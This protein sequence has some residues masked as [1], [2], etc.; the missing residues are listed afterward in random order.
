[1]RHFTFVV[2]LL[3]ISLSSTSQSISGKVVDS[4]KN[5]AIAFA[6]ISLSDGVRGTTSDIEG[7][8]SLRI[9]ADYNG[10]ILISHV[11]Y[12]RVSLPASYFKKAKTIRLKPSETVLSELT[13]FAE[14]NPAFRIIRKAVANREK[15]D[16]DKL[17]SYQYISYNKFLVTPDDPSLKTD[18]LIKKLNAKDRSS[19]SENQKDFL[20]IDSLYKTAHV[21]LSESV[22]EKKV[23]NPDKEI[24][25][26]LAIKVS[27]FKSPLFTN[28]ATDY[29]TFSFYK[30]KITLLQKDF[31][32][33]ISKGTL[34]RY[35]FYL[36]DTSYN[37][38]DTI[39]TIQFEPKQFKFFNGLKGMISIT[40]DGFAVKNVIA[41]DADTLALANIRIQQNYEKIDGH[42]FPTQLNTDLLFS[43]LNLFGR[44]FKI[45]H[46][47][48]LND[49]Q[50]N[51]ELKRILFGDIKIELSVPKEKENILLLNKYRVGT[52]EAKEARTYEYMDSALSK[53]VK[54][55]KGLEALATR[56]IPFRSLDIDINN[57]VRVNDYENFRLGLG[58]FTNDK[59]SKK[60]RLGG[61]YGYGFG[62]TRSKYGGETKLTFSQTRDFFVRFSYANDI[63]ETGTSYYN[64]EGQFLQNETYRNWVASQFDRLEMFKGEL[65]YR[66]LPDVHASAF[67]S[68]N[69]ITPT[70]QYDLLLDGELKNSFNISE[71]GIVLR[72]VKGETYFSLNGKKA[73]ISQKFPVI[74]FSYARAVNLFGSHNF[75]YAH[76]DLTL[77]HE[78]KHRTI[79]RTKLQVVGGWVDGVAPYGKLFNGR[80]ASATQLFVDGFFQTMRLYEFTNSQFASVFINHNVGNI[81][82]NKS[83]SKPEL[84]LYHNFGIG[85]LAHAEVHQN[86]ILQGMEKGYVESGVGLKN[87]IRINYLDLAYFGIGGSVFYRYGPYQLPKTIDNLTFRLDA[88]LAF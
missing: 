17:R 51:P 47:T 49:I 65:S 39:Y 56:A 5:E 61:Y 3:F 84:I 66:I 35:D 64:R 85:Q 52:I 28:V 86:I 38:R 37:D 72:Y 25:K 60:I 34:N 78:I 77:K 44:G 54:V 26:L 57:I 46:R 70:Y 8:F 43:Q 41:T 45:Q 80:G 15:H 69:Q 50:I 20:F 1:M 40:T 11:S 7:N 4:L 9:P 24:E 14:E 59:I 2:I 73:F 76:Y 79:G 82:V 6:N 55:E 21:F 32:N 67:L 36:T 83:Y 74:T 31:T 22:T 30:D 13:F 23:L 53:V 42:W 18:T 29:Q 16:P 62:D 58:L 63:Y 33:P 68:N 87:L 71:T 27:G 75:Q 81:L 48:F 19:L 12:Q 88:S 10:M